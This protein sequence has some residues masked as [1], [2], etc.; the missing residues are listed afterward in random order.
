MPDTAD[1]KD[2]NLVVYAYRNKDDPATAGV[3][4]IPL[5]VYTDPKY[6]LK[7]GEGGLPKYLLSQGV[8]AANMRNDETGSGGFCYLLNIPALQPPKVNVTSLKLKPKDVLEAIKKLS[9]A[10]KLSETTVKEIDEAL[11]RI[12]PKVAMVQ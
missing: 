3:F 1:I 9:K 7:E 11:S 10:S 5:E 8:V 6:E 4:S 2:T 12:D